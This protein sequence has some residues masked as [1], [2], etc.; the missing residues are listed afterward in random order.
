MSDDN[1]LGRG[2][3]PDEEKPI[4]NPK[5]KV[6]SKPKDGKKDEAYKRVS[7]K[8]R[9]GFKEKVEKTLKENKDGGHK[10]QIRK[11][12]E[13]VEEEVKKVPGNVIERVK[14]KIEGDIEGPDGR[15]LGIDEVIEGKPEG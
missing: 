13:A 3:R 15:P 8:V 10:K 2:D 6:G 9:K 14:V 7:K 11:A 12:R 5:V 4:K 1:R